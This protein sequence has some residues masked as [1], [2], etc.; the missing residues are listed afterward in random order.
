MNILFLNNGNILFVLISDLVHWKHLHFSWLLICLKYSILVLQ[1]LIDYKASK[2]NNMW[3]WWQP[4]S[5]QAAFPVHLTV[6]GLWITS[7]LAQHPQG[8]RPLKKKYWVTV[9]VIGGSLCLKS[10][11]NFFLPHIFLPFWPFFPYPPEAI[12]QHYFLYWC[13]PLVPRPR[14][15]YLHT[16]NLLAIHT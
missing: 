2:I 9:F 1:I 16:R 11:W 8:S 10:V 5:E 12:T 15:A 14:P 7:Q 13:D 6:P 3:F 4:C